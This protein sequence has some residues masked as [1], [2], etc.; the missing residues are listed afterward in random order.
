LI[1]QAEEWAG[2]D[3]MRQDYFTLLNRVV[4]PP[5]SPDVWTA[6]DPF[7]EAFRLMTE[8]QADVKASVESAADECQDK[9]DELWQTYNEL[10]Q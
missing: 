1:D 8:E 7:Y 10:G 3:P 4:P 2:D 9:L 6:V 5:F